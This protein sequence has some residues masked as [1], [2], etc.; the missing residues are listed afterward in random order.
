MVHR[1]AALSLA[2]I[3]VAAPALA[4]TVIIVR[5]GE[6]AAPTGDPDLS[7]AGQARAQALARAL[8]SA[9]VSVVLATPA[10]RTQQTAQPTAQA[11]GVPVV[12]IAFDGATPHAQRVADRARQAAASATVLVVGH[13]DT[14]AD[15]ARA[16]GDP[17]PELLNDC[18]YD[19]MTVLQLGG[20]GPPKAVHTRY[21][22]P[23]QSC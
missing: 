6:K 16:L 9:R 12:S 20:P 19:K 13:S 23:A 22:A 11:A 3:L 21:G 7:P 15:I 18:D 14:V 10:K 17:A 1:L 8:V 2:S 4:Q 5:H